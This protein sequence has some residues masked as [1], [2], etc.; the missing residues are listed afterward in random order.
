LSAQ[1][2]PAPVSTKTAATSNPAIRFMGVFS[3]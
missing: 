3:V 2:I 1:T